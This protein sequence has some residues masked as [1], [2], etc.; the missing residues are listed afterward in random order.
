MND[1]KNDQKPTPEALMQLQFAMAASR[2]LMVGTALS[3]FTDI[4][5]GKNTAKAIADASGASSRGV[6]MLLDSLSAFGL[7]KKNRE[8]YELTPVSAEYLVKGKGTYMGHMLENDMMW[9]SWTHLGEVVLSGKPLRRVEEKQNAESFFPTLV[10]SLHVANRAPALKTAQVLKGSRKLLDVACGSGVWGISLA[11]QDQAVRV[12]AQD[13]PALLEVTKEYATKHG[14][15]DRFEYLAGDLKTVDYGKDRFDCAILGNIVH[16]EGEKSSRAL[17]KK[18]HVALQAGGK[19]A[20]VDM[21]PN[22]DRSGPPFPVFFALNML[23]HTETG[24]TYTLSEY[25]SWLEDAG[26]KKVETADIGSHSPLIV[27]VK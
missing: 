13:F 18:L 5:K 3:V 6:R 17:F 20:I 1:Q 14:V 9:S 25:R 4:S 27:A 12:V 16:S 15:A 21:I 2:V 26:F 11:E 10:R 24:D 8:T 19:L 22:E 23:L 7:L